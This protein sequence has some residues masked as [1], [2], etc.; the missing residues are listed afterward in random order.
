MHGQQ[1][2][3]NEKKLEHGSTGAAKSVPVDAMEGLAVKLHSVFLNLGTISGEWLT[4]RCGHLSP[5]KKHRSPSGRCGKEKY[6]LPLSGF[7]L[8]PAQPIGYSLYGLRYS[9]S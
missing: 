7:E 1:N 5:R 9:G 2:V 4:S 3:K 8:R 6:L